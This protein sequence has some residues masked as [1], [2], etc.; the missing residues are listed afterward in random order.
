MTPPT[1]TLKTPEFIAM[2]AVLFATL[3]FSIDA[4][5]PA[6]PDIAAELTPDAPNRAQLIV[7]SFVF[8]MGFGTIFTGPLSDS[9][10][11]KPVISIGIG[12]YII[13][14]IL[15]FY[16]NTL[17]L[18]LVARAIQGIGA[19]AP[20][21]V[22]MAITR[23]MYEG[24]RMA[25]ITSFMMTI[26]MLVPAIAPS[27]GAVIINAAGWRYI[28]VAFVIFSLIGFTWLH[29]R[30]P[31]TLL[32]DQ[33]RPLKM[34]VVA[35]AAGEV[36]RHK[37]VMLYIVVLTLGFTQMMGMVTSIQP[38]YEVSYGKG[39]SFPFWFA[40]SAIVGLV[41]TLVN[42]ALV[43]RVGMRK[44]VI[45]SYGVQTIIALAFLIATQF[46]L[47]PLAWAFPVWF[48]WSVTL[49][50]MA[51]LTFGN[52][53]ALALQP[54]GHIAGTA[55]SVVAAISTLVSVLLAIPIGQHFNGTPVPLLLGTLI[56]SALAYAL[57]LRSTE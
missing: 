39:E 54:M 28:F 40:L 53:N 56:C 49:F 29:L 55:S 1:K 44:L 18:L 4:M 41:G 6:F 47:L 14:S 21:I 51:G 46:E 36:L 57:M 3:A 35:S 25:Q 48:A 10:G 37:A 13:G 24:R 50:F 12:I 22:P 45:W 15:A 43:I 2:M 52:L 26:F 5:L 17:E 32:P 20:R 42:A 27:L 16:A 7:L 11:R 30:Q 19:A 34:S 23:D 38:I 31:E 33:R 9:Y 8:G